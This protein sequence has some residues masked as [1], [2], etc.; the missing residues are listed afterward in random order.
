FLMTLA[1]L[2][3]LLRFT[4]RFLKQKSGSAS[5]WF[6]STT[7]RDTKVK[8]AFFNEPAASAEMEQPWKIVL[9][10]LVHLVAIMI[11][12]AFICP[13]DSRI[14]KEKPISEPGSG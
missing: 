1:Q 8:H 7:G 5:V 9:L 10:F 13:K 11:S 6:Q 2:P 12:D 4:A 3:G 14:S